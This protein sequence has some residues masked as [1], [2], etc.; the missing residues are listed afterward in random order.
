MKENK[1]RKYVKPA[2]RVIKLNPVLPVC[3][4]LPRGEEDAITT[5]QW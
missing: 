3:F 5:V 2:M 4:S 1:K